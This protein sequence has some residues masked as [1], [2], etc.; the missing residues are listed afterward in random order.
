M[1]G[2]TTGP[3]NVSMICHYSTSPSNK[4][5]VDNKPYVYT[6][7]VPGEEMRSSPQWNYYSMC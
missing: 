7:Q 6:R 5:G 2:A 1:D 4:T 3:V